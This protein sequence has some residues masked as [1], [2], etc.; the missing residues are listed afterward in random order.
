MTKVATIEAYRRTGKAVVIVRRGS[1]SRRYHASLRRYNALR[2]WAARGSHR[3]VTSGAW[4]RHGFMA[5]FFMPQ[6][7]TD[8]TKD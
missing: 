6:E 3:W 7:V 1:R 4:Q 8:Q 2:Q 5:S